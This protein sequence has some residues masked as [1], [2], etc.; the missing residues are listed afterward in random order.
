M[1]H[2]TLAGEIRRPAWSA[3]MKWNRSAAVPYAAS[4]GQDRVNR[5]GV[6]TH[7]REA[8]DPD[9]KPRVK[10]VGQV[11]NHRKRDAELYRHTRGRPAAVQPEA[12]EAARVGLPK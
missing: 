2:R 11:C 3:R 9:G 1:K 4:A 12:T 8:T 6:D 5:P 7:D 10:F